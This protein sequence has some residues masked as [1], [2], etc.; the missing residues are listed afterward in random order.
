MHLYTCVHVTLSTNIIVGENYEGKKRK[1]S[2]LN[3]RKF[4]AAESWSECGFLY[5]KMN[6]TILTYLNGTYYNQ[7]ECMYK[8]NQVTLIKP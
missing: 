4:Y 7:P 3:A 6:D 8:V 2:I 1:F 5:S